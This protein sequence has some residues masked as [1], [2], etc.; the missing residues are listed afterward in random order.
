MRKILSSIVAVCMVATTAVMATFPSSSQEGAESDITSIKFSSSALSVANG[1]SL[2]LADEVTVFCGTDQLASSS[3]VSFSLENNSDLAFTINGSSVTAI[4]NSGSATIVAKANEDTVVAKA[5]INATSSATTQYATSF[6]FDNE[7]ISLPVGL[8]AESKSIIVKPIP[9]TSSFTSS[10]KLAIETLAEQFEITDG[11]NIASTTATWDNSNFVMTVDGLD[12][13]D[14]FEQVTLETLVEFPRST[15]ATSTT[16]IRKNVKVTG[17][18]PV[19]PSIIA[20]ST[21]AITI[22]VGEVKDLSN[23]I[24]YAPSTSNVNVGYSIDIDYADDNALYND[25]AVVDGTEVKGIAVGKTKVVAT[26]NADNSQQAT[27]IVEVV[28][29]TATV[30][31]PNGEIEIEKTT[32]YV[33]EV[34]PVS[35]INADA[36]ATITWEISDSEVA[37]LAVFTGE[38]TN[39]YPKSEGTVE[40]SAM[41]DGIKVDSVTITVNSLTSSENLGT[42]TGTTTNPATSDGWLKGLFF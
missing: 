38:T 22:E 3:V 6:S 27:I 42:G 12:T 24:K 33:N 26:L 7:L 2:D 20:T 29:A 19:A 10:Q 23:I 35:V 37:Q 40:L 25:Y 14:T 15:D 1:S 9:T 11:V 8:G 41:V 4:E 39:I 30:T 21:S 36:D 28:P 16:T 17:V 32:L 5:T 18:E 31:L 13:L 34:T